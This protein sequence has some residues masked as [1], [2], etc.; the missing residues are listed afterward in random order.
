MK[1][2]LKSESE[3][4]TSRLCMAKITL[5]GKMDGLSSYVHLVSQL[6]DRS[7]FQNPAVLGAIYSWLAEDFDSP[8]EGLAFD[9]K[10]FSHITLRET[11]IDMRSA[12]DARL[13]DFPQEEQE[14]GSGK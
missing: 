8:E 10:F 1:I 14:D 9:V 6:I 13:K 2:T 12:I 7:P 4:E 3:D 5:Q 11:L